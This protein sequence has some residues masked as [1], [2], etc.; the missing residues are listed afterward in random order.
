VTESWIMASTHVTTDASAAS[1]SKVVAR[2]SEGDADTM[3]G[4]GGALYWLIRPEGLAAN[5]FESVMFTWQ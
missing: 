2:G 5:G 3:W 4:D 1:T